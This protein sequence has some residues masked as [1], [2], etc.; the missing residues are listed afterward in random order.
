MG[1]LKIVKI[2][3]TL[4]TNKV[5]LFVNFTL[6]SSVKYTNIVHSSHSQ[7]A[8]LRGT[9]EAVVFLEQDDLME[10]ILF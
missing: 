2:L 6:K 3:R 4:S 5:K 9:I 10:L 1:E 7:P 8:V